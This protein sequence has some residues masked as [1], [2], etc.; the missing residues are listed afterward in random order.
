[1]IRWSW[2]AAVI[3]GV[4]LAIAFCMWTGQMGETVFSPVRYY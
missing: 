2:I 4:A 1:M 3:L